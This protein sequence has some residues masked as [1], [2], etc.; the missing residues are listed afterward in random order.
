MASSFKNTTISGTGALAVASGTVDQRPTITKTIVPFLSGSGTWTVPTGVTSIELL[1]VGGGGGGGANSGGSSYNDG[2]G[3]GGAGGLI[4]RPNYTVSPGAVLNYSVGVAGTAGSSSQGGNGGNTTF[5]VLTAYGGGGGGMGGGNQSGGTALGLSGGSGGGSV[6]YTTVQPGASTS[7]PSSGSG[8]FGNSGS[9]ASSNANQQSGGGGG[10]GA[11]GGTAE[12][13]VNASVGYSGAG[14]IGLPFDISGTMTYYGGGGGGGARQAGINGAGGLGGGGAGGPYQGTATAGAT[15]TG[16]GGGGAGSAGSASAVAGAAGGSGVIYIRY[17]SN[18]TTATS[19]GIV[20]F[21]GTS[22]HIEVYQGNDWIGQNPAIN[23]AGHNL[24]TYSQDL[25][26]AVWYKLNISVTGNS[27]VAPDGTTTGNL[28]TADG[29]SNT[30]RSGYSISPATGIYMASFYAKAG[31]NNFIQV[32]T[33]FVNTDYANYNLSTGQLG[34]VGSTATATITSV[35]NGWYRCTLLTGSNLSANMNFVIITSATSVRNESNTL[36]TTVYVWGAQIES[37]VSQAGPYT[38]TTS[39]AS[40]TP[41]QL[42]GYN[43]HS[44]TTVGT[45]NW[46]PTHSGQVEILV[47]AGGGGGG[48]GYYGGGGGAGGLLYNQKHF[49]TA[50]TTYAVTVGGGGDGSTSTTSRGTNGSNSSFG[51]VVAIGGGGGGSRNNDAAGLPSQGNSGGSGGGGSFPPMIGGAGV[52]GQGY[53]GGGTNFTGSGGTAGY[54]SGGGGAGGPGEPGGWNSRYGARGGAGISIAITG[55]AVYY[56]GGGGGGGTTDGAGIGNLTGG[57]LG[58]GG[59][60]GISASGAG[61]NAT[62]NTGGGGG[63]GGGPAAGGAGGSGIVV[64]RYLTNTLIGIVLDGSSPSRAAPNAA[65]IKSLTGTTTNGLYWINVPTVGPMQVYCDMTTAGGGWMHCATFEDNNET[66]ENAY[67]H[68]WA[69]PLHNTQ[70]TGIW[71]DT[72]IL[73]TLSFTSNYKNNVWNYMPITQMLMKDQGNT[74]RNI[75]YT[76][77]S[78]MSS[79]TLSAFW[80]ARQWLATGSDSSQGGTGAIANGRVYYQT[81]TNF[82]VADPVFNITANTNNRI[83]F[84]WGEIDGVQDGNKDRSMISVEL[85]ASTDVD[86]PKG[87]GCHTTLTAPNFVYR[88]IVPVA[89]AADSPPS[90]ITGTPYQLSL[91]VR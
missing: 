42:N 89:Q 40:P 58:G 60:G 6:N 62:A 54:G 74:L 37:Y 36:S 3:G 63:G 78:Q 30:H 50:G 67:N 31:T 52:P 21:D 41:T 27:I 53:H 48:Y 61:S 49:V 2:G 79:Q 73:G 34:T 39:I 47:V 64:V 88:N 85:A 75:W 33:D 51:T 72:S 24:L 86:S 18:L 17:V 11:A 71:Q 14:G 55:T 38:L 81:I 29:T 32:Y 8:G 1:M 45:T 7:Q 66:Y 12:Y 46:V 80:A 59:A 35:G 20:R 23:Y 22:G 5:D 43:I 16:G 13:M 26:N 84:K 57:G 25:T 70:Y 69:A 10:A 65:Y 91:W 56:A 4:Y 82:G 87:I 76:N 83:L 90:S 68:P 44:F 77:A 9:P 19:Q 15:N 28:L